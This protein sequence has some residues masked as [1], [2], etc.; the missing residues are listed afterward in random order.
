MLRLTQL[1]NVTGHPAIS[2]PSG[3]TAAGLPCSIQLVG[4]RMQTDAL[5]QVALAC[6]GQIGAAPPTSGSVGV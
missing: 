6:E 3:R 1:F 2:L 5:L 4:R